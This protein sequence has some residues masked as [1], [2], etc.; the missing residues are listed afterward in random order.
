M[1]LG[2]MLQH[3]RKVVDFTNDILNNFVSI[4]GDAHQAKVAQDIFRQEIRYERSLQ[5]RDDIRDVNKMMLE[6]V[7]T[8]LFIGSILLG[9]C[10]SMFVEGYPPADALRMF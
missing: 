2:S 10:F 5:I 7:Q 3:G 8:D 4:A 1:F 9:V 6:S